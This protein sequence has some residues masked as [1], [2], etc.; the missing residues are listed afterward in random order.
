M[1]T[2]PFL[3]PDDNVFPSG[4]KSMRHT[5][6]SCSESVAIHEPSFVLHNRT[7]LSSDADAMYF[8]HGE[9]HALVTLSECPSSANVRP[10]VVASLMCTVKSDIAANT[11][12]PS[13]ENDTSDTL[14]VCGFHTKSRSSVRASHISSASCTDTV[15]IRVPQGPKEPGLS[16]HLASRRALLRVRDATSQMRHGPSPYPDESQCPSGDKQIIGIAGGSSPR[17]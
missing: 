9:K 3:A 2:L 5:S 1:K 10:P 16:N 17:L 11:D 13:G 7:V 15:A 6:L 8:P 4:E 14:S 12:F